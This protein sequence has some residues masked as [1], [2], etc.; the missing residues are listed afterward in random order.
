MDEF[1]KSIRRPFFYD[2]IM[3]NN[4]VYFSL[5]QYNALCQASLVDDQIEI[6]NTFPNMPAYKWRGYVGVYKLQERLLLSSAE[7]EDNLLLYDLSNES[8][9]RIINNKKISFYSFQVFDYKENFYIV[10]ADTAEIVKIETEG[11]EMRTF[12]NHEQVLKDAETGISVRLGNRIYIPV[13]K[14]K[15]LLAFDLEKEEYESFSFP[16]NISQIF[17]MSYHDSRFF[18]SGLDRR[19]Y[20]WKLFDEKADEIAGIPEYVKPF[21]VGN[22]S[23]S[24]SLIY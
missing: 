11:L 13:N 7:Q 15:I 18:I 10:S 9:S 1:T 2:M 17:T 20:A 6:I 19:V 24:H 4:N 16:S 5:A 21:Y 12:D 14:K 8:F 3:D 23:F 22:V